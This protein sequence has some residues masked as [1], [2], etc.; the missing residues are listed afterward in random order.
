MILT[1]EGAHYSIEH[2]C[3]FLGLGRESV[4][5]IPISSSNGISDSDLTDAFLTQIKNGKR[6]AAIIACGGTT[7][8]FVCDNT[9]TIFS[10]VDKVVKNHNLDYTPYL[11]LDSVIG[12]LWFSLIEGAQDYFDRF[13]T[14]QR[15]ISKLKEVT[16]KFSHIHRFDSLGVDFHKNALCP[17]S[18]SFFITNGTKLPK[19]E[20]HLAYGDF[21]AFTHTIENSR[22]A[23]GI[24]SAWAALNSLGLNGLRN[25]LC[26]LLESAQN[27]KECFDEQENITVLNNS[28]CGW[29]IIFNFKASQDLVDIYS[30]NA[31]REG[32]YQ[33]VTSKVQKGQDIPSISIIKNFRRN[34]ASELG[35]GFIYYNMRPKLNYDECENIVGEVLRLII[36]YEEEVRMGQFLIGTIDFIDPIK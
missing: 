9:E 33:F 10:T 23:A 22:S 11:H 13:K 7:L 26:Q 36:R 19:Q 27:L 28:S 20:N 21:V 2:V 6:V 30:V 14:P 5:R 12:W 3:E 34:Y 8:D 15:V 29:E 17:Y 1:S 18:S 24:A 31:L 35:H 25:Y 4:V 32:F 16:D